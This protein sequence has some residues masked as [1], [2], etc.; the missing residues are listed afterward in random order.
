MK[1]R[2]KLALVTRRYPPLIGGAEKV[3]SYL[4]AAL[5]A[6]G[7]DV[8][9]L[10]AQPPTPVDVGIMNGSAA[11]GCE[12]PHIEFP[13]DGLKVERLATSKL[14]WW[15]TWLYMN[16][17]KNWLE[18]NPIDLAYVSMLKHDAYAVVSASRRSGFPVVLRP[19]GA[20]ATGDVAWQSWGRLGRRIG[21]RCR[22]AHA[23]VAISPA[24]E[25]EMHEAWKSGTMRPSLLDQVLGRSS[26]EPRVEAI[27]NGVPVPAVPWCRRPDWPA[28]PKAIFVG[29]LA[30][31]K[32][33]DTLVDAWALVQAQVSGS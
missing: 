16:N 23:F 5:A 19:E 18:R 26:C 29:R 15:G 17:L 2:L 9:V 24:I 22:Q 13:R 4:A 28:A 33:L 6:E 7:A 14:R 1:L 3:F 31:E 21:H 25:T 10:T 27:P 8:T 11:V 12:L 20:G 32:G 30:Q